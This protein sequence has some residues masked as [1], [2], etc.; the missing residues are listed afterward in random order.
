MLGVVASIPLVI[1]LW[2]VA[3][4]VNLMPARMARGLGDW[5]GFA[6]ATLLPIRRK[7]ALAN[8]GWAFPDQSVAWRKEQIKAMYRH[9]GRSFVELARFAPWGPER[10]LRGVEI[11]GAEHLKEAVVGG[12]GVLVLTAHLGNWELLARMGTVAGRPLSI[13]TRRFRSPAAE[14]TWRLLRRGGPRLLVASGSAR[15][16]VA[17]LGR[18]ELVGYV[19]DQHSPPGRAVRVPFFGHGAATCKD[20]ARLA[21]LTGAPVVPIFTWRGADGRHRIR[22][23]PAVELAST[24]DAASRR[25]ENTARFTGRIEAAVRAHPD[26]WLWIHR[27]WK[28]PPEA[29]S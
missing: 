28:P 8:I 12:R 19:L 10:L 21:V 17:A 9:F 2:V 1:L 7:V 18:G 11:E 27:R 16:I 26:Q 15:A 13:V 23:E 5:L 25:W 4:G 6:W 14:W 3:L 24:G 20:L 29:G 22:V